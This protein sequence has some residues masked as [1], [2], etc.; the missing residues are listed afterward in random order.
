MGSQGHPPLPT[1]H[2]ED[3]APGRG[4]NNRQVQDWVNF[5]IYQGGVITFDPDNLDLACCGIFVR[6]VGFYQ[7]PQLT[8]K[9][10]GWRTLLGW[11]WL[12]NAS[13]L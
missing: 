2:K 11:I 8:S 5:N 6:W 3:G 13:F 1:S 12:G 4:P 10:V 9:A 7:V